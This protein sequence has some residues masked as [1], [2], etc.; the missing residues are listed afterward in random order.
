MHAD[1]TPPASALDRFRDAFAV[2]HQVSACSAARALMRHEA[3]EEPNLGAL[4]IECYADGGVVVSL[5]DAAGAP[6][7]GYTL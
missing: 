1:H 2:A 3:E 4:V 7:T 6:I 5:L